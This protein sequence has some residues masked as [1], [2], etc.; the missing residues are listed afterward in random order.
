MVINTWCDLLGRQ[1]QLPFS[2]A[3]ICTAALGTRGDYL[4]KLFGRFFLSFSLMF[5]TLYLVKPTFLNSTMDC[6]LSKGSHAIVNF[7]KFTKN[8]AQNEKKSWVEEKMTNQSKTEC[9]IFEI[10]NF[11]IFFF[12]SLSF[13]NEVRLKNADCTRWLEI[14]CS[15]RISQSFLKS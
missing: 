14:L 12:K 13:L 4:P 7:K 8:C 5:A 10:L 9:S 15:I 11:N 6:W 1:W 3:S 2:L